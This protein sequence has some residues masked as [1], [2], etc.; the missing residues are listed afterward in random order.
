M[1]IAGFLFPSNIEVHI[2]KEYTSLA[3]GVD[4]TTALSVVAFFCPFPL[5][6]ASIFP[7]WVRRQHFDCVSHKLSVQ[8]S[9]FPPVALLKS[10]IFHS[11]GRR[12]LLLPEYW[13][14][15]ICL[16]I[17]EGGKALNDSVFCTTVLALHGGVLGSLRAFR[18][19]W[20]D[21]IG[22]EGRQSHPS[23][24]KASSDAGCSRSL[25]HPH[26]LL[27]CSYLSRDITAS[28]GS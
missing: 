28:N 27:R 12:L 4:Q 5:H 7:S 11:T 24:D 15:M 20:H 2:W 6:P 18:T 13:T 10:L 19:C 8:V 14:A 25:W 23:S 21:P 17:C 16:F 22:E 3:D 26:L 1:R 9:V